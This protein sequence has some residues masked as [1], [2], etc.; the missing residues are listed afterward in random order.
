MQITLED[1]QSGK[2]QTSIYRLLTTAK[3]LGE[4]TYHQ[5][6]CKVWLD[7]EA[8]DL[9]LEALDLH[10]GGCKVRVALERVREE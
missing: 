7:L 8:G 2:L 6:T 5:G 1:L 4:F 3:A 9:V 10:G